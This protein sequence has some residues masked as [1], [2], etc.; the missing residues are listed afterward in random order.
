MS[1]K[2]QILAKTAVFTSKSVFGKN[3]GFQSKSAVFDGFWNHDVQASD[4]VRPFKRETKEV[5]P[6]DVS[7]HLK[8][9][10]LSPSGDLNMSIFARA[11]SVSK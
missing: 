6:E 1:Q 11:I 10:S 8:I 9:P 4:Q 2:A 7:T 3:C 5:W